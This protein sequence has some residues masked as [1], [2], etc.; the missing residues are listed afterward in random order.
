MISTLF[1][2]FKLALLFVPIFAQNLQAQGAHR[3]DGATLCMSLEPTVLDPTIAAGQNIREIAHMNI[4]EGLSAIDRDGKVVPAL[5]SSWEVSADGL[6]YTFHLRKNASFHDGA[7][8]TAEDVKFTFARAMAPN[9][10]NIE[11]WIFEPIRAIAARDAHTLEITLNYETNL[12]LYGLAWGDAAI[13]SPKSVAQNATHPIGTGP[14]KFKDWQRGNKLAVIRN[15][16]WWGGKPPLKTVVYRFISDQQAT[17]NAILSGDCDLVS[18]GI[19]PELLENLRKNPDLTVTAGQTEGET[20]LAINN[21]KKPFDD[22]RVRRALSHAIDRKA[23]IEGAM[24]GYGTPI[25]SHFSPNHPAYVDLTS[26]AS[27][28]PVKARALLASA[29]YKDGFAASISLPPLSYARRSAEIIAEQLKAVG[30]RI[31]LVPLEF[32][33]WLERVYKNKDYDLSIIAHTEPLDIKNYARPTYYFQYN[34]PAFQQLIKKAYRAP[35]ESERNA[36]LGEA[37]KMLAEDAVS[38]FLFVLPK[39]TLA[40]KGLAGAWLN[41]P[42]A[43]TPLSELSWQ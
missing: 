35:T 4:F 31:T 28:D 39:I 38:V 18:A 34:S 29:G 8:F 1:R 5:A 11:K 32:P 22:I 36:L 15:E 40:R 23:V 13:F 21:A 30:L 26:Y 9:S 20:I 43:V 14:Y 12:F 3:P 7:P 17:V 27:Y 42:M 25:G 24:S 33:Q 37:Q 41:W 16:Q 6:R 10:K 2:A 19:A